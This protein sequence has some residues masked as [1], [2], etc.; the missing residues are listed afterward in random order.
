MKKLVE[1]ELILKPIRFRDKAQ[2]DAV[3]SV[4]RDWLSPWEATRPNIDSKSPLPSYYGMVMQ[5][6]REIRA[7]RSIALGIWLKEN[8][9]EILIGQITLGGIIF[10]AMRGAHIGYWIDQRFA[11][12]GYTTRSV[13]LLTK[14]GFDSL[15][16]HRI[17]IN[18][19]PE[20]EASKQVAIKAGYE[21]EGARK[22][23]LHIAGDWRN[24]IT[25]VKENPAVK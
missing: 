9:N 13:K 3:R 18:L 21:L 10:G 20:N 16:L 5:L 23:Y 7:V 25:F 11:N 15:K 1:N 4:N 12:Q 8:R 17:E 2:W 24:H 22:N 19:R 6:N 14:F